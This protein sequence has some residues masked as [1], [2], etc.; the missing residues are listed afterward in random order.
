[1]KFARLEHGRAIKAHGEDACG[2]DVCALHNRTEHHMRGWPQF[3]RYDSG[4]MER[5][6][7]CGVGHPDPDDFRVRHD[8][9]LNVHGCCGCCVRPS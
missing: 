4:I 7:P 6:C 3:F 2:G 1:M 9:S 5:I 8:P